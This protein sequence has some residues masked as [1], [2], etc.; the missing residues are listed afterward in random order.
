MTIGCSGAAK[1][2]SPRGRATQEVP[3]ANQAGNGCVDGNR[4]RSK[5]AVANFQR[6]ILATLPVFAAYLL[7]Q[8]LLHHFKITLTP[9]FLFY[10]AFVV[11]ARQ[12]GLWPGL[13]SLALSSIF[14]GKMITEKVAG[15][16]VNSLSYT[17]SLA[18]FVCIGVF[19]CIMMERI[20][21]K[22][23]KIIEL[24]K[25][26]ALH[27]SEN[28]LQLFI[29][30][31]PASVMVIMFDAE[32]RCRA[33]SQSWV[34]D[35]AFKMNGLGKEQL[36]GRSH[37]E[38][39]PELPELYKDAHRRGLQGEVVRCTGDRY[40]A[41][42]G[43]EHWTSWEVA[44]WFKGNG[45]VGGIIIISQDIT[46]RKQ[47]EEALRESR[48]LLQLFIEYA[49]ASL[50][51]FDC[52]MRY[53]AA[54]RRYL[55]EQSL[56]GREIAGHCIYEILPDLPE[57]RKEAHRRGLAGEVV[58]HDGVRYK[59]A[60]GTEGWML[61]E[62][63][64]WLKGDGVIGGVVISAEDVTERG[65]AEESLRASETRYRTAFQTSLDAMCIARR[66]DGM[67]IDFNSTFL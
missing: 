21:H 58:R 12:L 10:P 61:S 28:L 44:P 49:P 33:V 65:L 43:R 17:V 60:D 15:R 62:V 22:E 29:D 34:N 30:H 59:R 18:L 13:F 2:W 66:S 38:A 55:E 31:A 19:L 41:K 37:Y 1:A 26:E 35:I 14:A 47:A 50:A 54:S 11:I 9:F 53:L 42:D 67:F 24:E 4:A 57:A 5:S 40:I 6:Y 8:E 48:K 27:E 56:V 46:E 64:P 52:E 36:I 63:H 45:Q 20:R 7:Q 16:G 23:Q 51:M 25:K 3:H 39:F 32:M